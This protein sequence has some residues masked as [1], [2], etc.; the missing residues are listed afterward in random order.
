MTLLVA[1]ILTAMK[2]SVLATD[3]TL[4]GFSGSGC[5]GNAG[6]T[7]LCGDGS[8]CI[9]WENPT[10]VSAQLTDGTSGGLDNIFVK[11]WQGA[12]CTGSNEI[13]QLGPGCQD[14]PTGAAIQCC[15]QGLCG[16][17]F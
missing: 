7:D 17:A 14:I 3:A 1:A 8:R 2:S 16:S 15:Q 13:L 9:L 12:G 5:T 6:D 10:R 11:I 4:E